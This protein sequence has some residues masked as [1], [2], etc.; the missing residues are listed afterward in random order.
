MAATA[1]SGAVSVSTGQVRAGAGLAFFVL[2][3]Q[4]MT[5]IMLGA[6]IAPGYDVQNGAISDLGVAPATA[7]LF[8]TSLILTGTLNLLAAGALYA[9]DR[10]IVA[11]A[12]GVIAGIGA[13][14]A[15]VFSLS[16]QGIHGIFALLAFIFFNL[17]ILPAALNQKGPIRAVG[18]V[19]AAVGLTYIVIM[20]IG[21]AGNP[22]VFGPIG[23]GG[24]E[25]MI[26]Y[27][28]MLWLMAYGGL[29][30]ASWSR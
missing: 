20:V 7:L 21:D 11:L 2:S 23:H 3:A 17:Q 1:S 12:L 15:G 9:L 25:R 29:L 18:L 16:T 8:N 10:R 13:I 27:P 14:G 5:A 24:S 30:M 28:P 26:A 19:L 4:F 22:A 6:S